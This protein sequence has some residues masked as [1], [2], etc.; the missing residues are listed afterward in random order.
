M[1]NA[2]CEIRRQATPETESS[3]PCWKLTGEGWAIDTYDRLL[4][5]APPD[6]RDV[7]ATPET[8]SSAPCWKLT[9][10]GWAIDVY[11]RLLLWVPPDL[12]DVLVQYTLSRINYHPA[13][14]DEAVQHRN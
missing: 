7:L 6:L 2:R 3:A 14:F 12:R 1:W 10:E 5:W 4:L 8:E 9:G 13:L 11:D